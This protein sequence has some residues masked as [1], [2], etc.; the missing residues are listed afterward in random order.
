VSMFLLGLLIEWFG[1]SVCVVSLL[2]GVGSAVCC[3][4]EVIVLPDIGGCFFI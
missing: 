3:W 2:F 1:S 4:V